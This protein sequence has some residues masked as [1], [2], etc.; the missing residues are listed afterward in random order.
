MQERRKEQRWPAYLGARITFAPRRDTVDCLVRNTSTTGVR[1]VLDRAVLLPDEFSLQIAKHR[2]E[3]TVR[4]R[5]RRFNDVG[6]ELA[7][8]EADE[9]I[10]L[11]L[12]RRMRDLEVS[13]TTLKR[14]LADMTE[15]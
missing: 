4:T 13:N 6:V 7:R 12:A 5:W 1:L 8:G 3:Y 14:R 10:D 9:P 2:I 15:A 11:E